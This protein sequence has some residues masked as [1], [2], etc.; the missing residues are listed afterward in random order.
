[1]WYP[2]SFLILLIHIF[3]V[4]HKLVWLGTHWT[5]WSLPMTCFWFCC[6]Y[7]FLTTIKLISIISFLL[8]TLGLIYSFL[9]YFPKR[10]TYVIYCIC[11]FFTNIYV[12]IYRYICIFNT[13]D[14]HQAM[15]LLHLTNFDVVFWFAVSW[16]CYM[17]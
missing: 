9:S 2:L 16:E 15:F 7:W 4:F 1:M 17:V 11:F 6:F 12:N 14:F 8:L 5:Y 3:S 10:G 13:I